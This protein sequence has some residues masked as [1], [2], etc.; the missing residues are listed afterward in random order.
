MPRAE[1]ILDSLT[2]SPYFGLSREARRNLRLGALWA[3]FASLAASALIGIAALAS[4]D[5]GET[6]GKLLLTTFSFFGG[7]AITLACGFA[8]ERGRLGIVPVLGMVSG[9]VG[10]V[11]VLVGI[12]G[13]FES[14]LWWKAFTSEIMVALAATHASLVA[15]FSA[16]QR[17]RGGTYAA[18]GLGA[19]AVALTLIAVWGGATN[20]GFWRFYGAVMVLLLALTIALP[21]L[22]RIAGPAMDWD[23][24]SAS[25]RYCPGCGTALEPPGMNSC[26]ACGARFPGRIDVPAGV[27]TPSP[28]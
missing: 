27:A 6:E 5:F 13:D 20:D 26:D 9:L 23:R 4:T 16:G 12:W 14:D 8:W 18:Y 2:R 1:D 7:S 10:L 21:V 15:V 17:F 3:L 25:A 19:I 11:L 24:Q 22:R 28:D